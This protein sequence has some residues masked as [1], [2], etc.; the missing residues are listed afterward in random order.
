[1]SY[2]HLIQFM[3]HYLC[4]TKIMLPEQV[5]EDMKH[6]YGVLI[7]LLPCTTQTNKCSL[8]LCPVSYL[9]ETP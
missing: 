6:F 2:Y 7:K 5:C 3:K 1:M 8:F 9:I 4:M